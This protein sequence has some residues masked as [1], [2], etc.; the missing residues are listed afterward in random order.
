MVTGNLAA[1]G[2]GHSTLQPSYAIWR[3][4]SPTQMACSWCQSGLLAHVC[5]GS[6]QIAILAPIAH[7][8]NITRWISKLVILFSVENLHGRFQSQG[9]TGRLAE[10]ADPRLRVRRAGGDVT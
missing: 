8:A 4:E 5:G 6:G 2:F 1:T 10:S 9:I 3:T 7:G